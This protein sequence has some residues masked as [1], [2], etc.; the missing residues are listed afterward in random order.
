VSRRRPTPEPQ[1]TPCPRCRRATTDGHL[2]EHCSWGVQQGLSI[3][4]NWWPDL[5]DTFTKQE[6]KTAH[7]EGHGLH[8]ENPLPFDPVAAELANTIRQTLVSWVKLTMDEFSAPCPKDRISTMAEHLRTWTPK[9][10]KHEVAAEY[11]DEIARLAG[12]VLKVID[13]AD[14]QLVHVPGAH[15][16]TDRG[17][18][19]CGGELVAAIR[20][21]WFAESFIRCRNCGQAWS[22]ADWAGVAERSMQL[23]DQEDA[24][25]DAL[26]DEPGPV[27]WA[28]PQEFARRYGLSVQYVYNAAKKHGWMRAKVGRQVVYSVQDVLDWRADVSA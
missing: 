11:A 19:R 17:G 26:N 21:D 5:F 18:M 15:C 2:C 22:A 16:I 25:A 10:R 27:A 4:V 1:E 23:D 24:A 6:R 28:T 12:R 20:R 9:L 14:G 7:T 13:T 8:H 3:I